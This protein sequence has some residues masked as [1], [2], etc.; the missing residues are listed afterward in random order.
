MP[1]RG[2]T[3][4]IDLQR[5]RADLR[6]ALQGKADAR[7]SRLPPAGQLPPVPGLRSPDDAR[8]EDL[9]VS[10]LR[11]PSYAPLPPMRE[12]RNHLGGALRLLG[13]CAVAAPIVYLFLNYFGA[14]NEVSTAVP[15][16]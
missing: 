3:Y 10:H 1:E 12:R 2:P 7:V 11:E 14:G 5:L 15:G 8:F 6:A 9:P 4:D 16:W 13:A